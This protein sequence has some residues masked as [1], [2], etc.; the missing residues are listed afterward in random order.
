LA[1]EGQFSQCVRV[2]RDLFDHDYDHDIRDLKSIFP[3][4]HKD[5]AGNPFWSG[6][7]RAPHP[8]TFNVEDE[9]HFNY[10]FSCANLIAFNLG[11]PQVRDAAQVKA[12]AKAY[13]GQAYV[14]K[15][16]KVE[17]PEEAK[18]REAA[19]A[20]AQQH[21]EAPGMNDEED[22]KNLVE[23]LATLTLA[24]PSGKIAAADF[25]KDDDSNFHIA[26]ITASSNLRARN[27]KIGEADFHKTKLIAGK[28]IP[29]I[30]TTTAMITGTVTNE[31]FKFVQGFNKLDQFKN[32]FINLAV[33]LFLFS[34]PDEVKRNKS[35]DYDPVMCGPIKCIPEG[36]TIFDKVVVN[37]GSMTFQ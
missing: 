10:V 9:L 35:K 25:E 4:D 21:M 18:A 3:D 7:K 11:V 8:I 17:T 14:A 23:Q 13:G 1:S 16:I 30:A 34:E 33:S 31:I 5:A 27:Y 36:Y 22:I 37:K 20:P 2:A 15:Q 12:I 6:P 19:G 29:A 26:F 32:G 28:I 24:V